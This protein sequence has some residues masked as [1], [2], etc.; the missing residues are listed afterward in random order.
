MLGSCWLGLFHVSSGG[1]VHA[2]YG[3]F[4]PLGLW[5]RADLEA[6]SGNESAKQGKDRVSHIRLV[7]GTKVISLFNFFG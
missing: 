7:L 6:T 2:F 3:L 1:L 4:H 5:I